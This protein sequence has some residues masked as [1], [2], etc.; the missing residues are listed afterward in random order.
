MSIG[1]SAMRRITWPD[2]SAQVLSVYVPLIMVDPLENECQMVSNDKDH[3]AQWECPS[4]VGLCTPY[5][6]RF[7]GK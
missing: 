6:G 7:S 4:P 1:Q 3:T 2:G 5:N